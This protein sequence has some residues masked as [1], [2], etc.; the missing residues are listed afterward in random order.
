MAIGGPTTTNPGLL[1]LRSNS[2]YHQGGRGR[3]NFVRQHFMFWFGE[4]TD[5]G[6][7]TEVEHDIGTNYSEPSADCIFIYI[8][9]YCICLHTE[10]HYC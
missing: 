1:G 8:N 4:N 7:K 9:I 3:H 5:L 6:K 10:M 2:L